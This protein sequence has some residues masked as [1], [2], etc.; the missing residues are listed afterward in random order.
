MECFKPLR[1]A[2]LIIFSKYLINL[3]FGHLQPPGL[4]FLWFSQDNWIASL[5]KPTFRGWFDAPTEAAAL[6]L[7]LHLVVQRRLLKWFFIPLLFVVFLKAD[8][9]VYVHFF[10]VLAEALHQLHALFVLFWIHRISPEF[11]WWVHFWFKDRLTI[12]RILWLIYWLCIWT[13]MFFWSSWILIC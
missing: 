3:P 2:L 12:F 4:L 13:H 1:N 5:L 8:T 7:L 10:A 11:H 9:P 6:A